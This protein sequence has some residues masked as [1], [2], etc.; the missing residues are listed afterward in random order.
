MLYYGR[1]LLPYDCSMAVGLGAI[2][3]GIRRGGRLRSAGVGLLAAV[4]VLIYP[5][6]WTLAGAALATHLAKLPDTAAGVWRRAWPSFA[7]FAAGLV[8]AQLLNRALTGGDMRQVITGYA[9]AVDQGTPGEGWSLPWEYLWHAEHGLLV[10]WA[11]GVLSYGWRAR[12][13]PM[14][15][16]RADVIALLVIYGSLVVCSVVLGMFVV[17]GRL[18][19][20]LVPFLSLLA[21]HEAARVFGLRKAIAIPAAVC[22]VAGVIIQAAF[23]FRTPLHQVFPSTFENASQGLV[24]ALK[25]GQFVWINLG[26]LYPSPEAPQLPSLFKEVAAAAHPVAY[27]PYQYEGWKPEERAVLRASD[28]RMRLVVI[29]P[30]AVAAR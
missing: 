6:Y 25:P 4:T 5:G 24:Q 27:L 13:A 18:A 26:R 17:Y 29:D 22:L 9:T 1:H 30:A 16:L 12:R 21:A 19:R 8:T 11:A 7:C 15:S 2:W 28:L 14:V 10:L 23:N 20:Q 3:F